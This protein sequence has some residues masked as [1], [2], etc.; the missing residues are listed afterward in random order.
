ME[1]LKQDH[2]HRILNSHYCTD[3][4]KNKYFIYQ[5]NANEIQIK[6]ASIVFE[7][8]ILQFFRV[9]ILYSNHRS[10]LIIQIGQYGNYLRLSGVG[11]WYDLRFNNKLQILQK[12]QPIIC[13]NKKH[14]ITI[15]INNTL[16]TLHSQ[17]TA[18]ITLQIC[19]H[20]QYIFI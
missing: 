1:N 9:H 8:K 4:H 13:Y 15:T 3:C 20:K 16:D 10:L 12:L 7:T 17:I 19:L 18:N 6:Y 5:F 11:E 14:K 2:V